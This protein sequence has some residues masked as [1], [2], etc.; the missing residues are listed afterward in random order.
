MGRGGLAGE[1]LMAART[2]VHYG[3]VVVAAGMLTLF[4]CIGIGRFGLGILLPAMGAALAL[5]YAEMGLVSTANLAGYLTSVYA[6]RFVVRRVGARATIASGL[7]VVALSLAGLALARD[8]AGAAVLCALTGIGIGIANVPM[9]GLVSLWFAR[10]HRG[11]AAGTLVIGNGLAIVYAGILIPAINA[12]EGADGWRSG[13]LAFAATVLACAIAAGLL[14]RN[15]PADLALAP[16]GAAADAAPADHGAP[17]EL[18]AA[19]RRRLLAEFGAIYALF[20]ASS[21]IYTTFIVVS[22]VADHGYSEAVAGRLWAWIGALSMLSGPLFGT[23]SDRIGRR[24]GLALVFAMQAL[25][26]ALAALGRDGAPL[27]LS[28]GLFGIVAWS[29]PSIMAAAVGD[30][31][32]PRHAADAIGTVTVIFGLG[33]ITGPAIAGFAADATQSFAA[34]FAIAAALAG[35]AIALALRLRPPPP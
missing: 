21:V 13:W 24:R 25:A 35:L 2:P 3:W 10:R 8:F 34:S 12:A 17:D 18:P 22:L 33:Q 16:V 31:M 23:L 27:Y 20:G 14:I 7:V 1:G 29:I 4:A 11:K 30:S 6:V 5:S 26:Y 32:G 19:A 15:Q 28:I 9:M